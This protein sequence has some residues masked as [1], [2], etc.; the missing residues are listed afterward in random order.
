M[1]YGATGKIL[2][3]NLSSKEIQIDE[4]NEEFYRLYI[5]GTLLG[6]YY[7][8]R[9]TTP[10][11]DAFDKENVIVFATSVVTGVPIPGL[12]RFSVISKSPLTG[13]L[14]ASEAGGW[15]GPELKFAGFDAVVISG[16]AEE[17]VYLWI[18]DGQIEIRNAS[19]VWGK[20]TKEAQEIIRKEIREPLARVA[21]IGPGGEK[22]VRYA[23]ILNELKHANGRCGLGAVM[24]S[25]N[26]KAV[27]VHGS[28][29]K[30]KCKD[31]KVIREIA[32]RTA[33]GYI[34]TP[35]GYIMDKL[36]TS[37]GILMNN[38]LGTLPTRNFSSGQFEEVEKISG[39]RMNETIVK[40]K[41]GCFACPV[42]CK[43]IVEA[44]LPY[45]IDSAY[46]GP[47]YETIAA[48]GSACGVDDLVAIAKANELCAANSLDTIS[49]GI[50]IAFAME[51]FENKV[52]TS[53]DTGGIEL[54]FGNAESMLK[55]VE[56][57]VKRAGFGNIL[58][59][60]VMRA[61]KKI[62]RGAE[63]YAMHV[64]G[65]EFPL[66]EPRGKGVGMGLGYALSPTG[67]EHCRS[68]PDTSFE[69]KSSRAISWFSHLGIRGT[70]DRMYL[71]P[72]KVRQ[73]LIMERFGTLV[74]TYG[75]CLIVAT[76]GSLISITDLVQIIR[77]TT[78]WDN[79][80]LR[81]LVDVADRTDNLAR[82][83]NIR[84]GFRRKDDWLPERMFEPL[85]G[86]K[87]KGLKL[88]KREFTEALTRYYEMRGWNSK[89]GI[90]TIGKLYE[91]EI[92]WAA[93]KF[94]YIWE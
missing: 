89:T 5:G 12:S 28:N 34:D 7:L 16:K 83:Y 82:I 21:I 86:G 38:A 65:Q 93:E 61:A 41:E 18:H 39:E 2:K 22:L 20:D 11:I 81:E 60:G 35:V 8:I 70:L 49:T 80:N 84:E 79:T 33:R 64:K 4:P 23:C 44:N 14:A 71:G 78:G 43:R 36:G 45:Q 48:L 47:E 72:E 90:P 42:R 51:C 30:V 75:I 24:G 92:G 26:L 62:G 69:K 74:N 1:V 87:N 25:K 46:G 67:A 68:L 3:V 56:L 32:K 55:M 59:E 52:I 29:R 31:L 73:F 91:L 54:R 13:G 58:A 50:S 37:N 94:K 19:N 27:V 88:D 77:S 17:P 53:Q 63:K 85:G 40:S 76:A 15:W 66:H 57:I 6:T 10:G 9:E